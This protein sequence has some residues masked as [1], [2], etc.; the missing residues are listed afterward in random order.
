[1][2]FLT[3]LKRYIR[4]RLKARTAHGVHS[5]F[6][7]KLIHEIIE[8]ENTDYYIFKELRKTR[9]GLLGNKEKITITDLGAGSKVFKGNVRTVSQIASAGTSRPKFSRL[10]FRLINFCHAKQI[11]ELGTSIGLNT[12]YLAK[13]DSSAK[14]YSIE[15]CSGLHQFA[16]KLLQA[17]E[18]KN[19]TLLNGNFDKVFPELLEQLP[20]L[21][22]LFV[23]GN[24]RYEP[25]I[26]Y[27]TMALEKKTDSSV[28][29][30][31]DIHWSDGMEKA[32]EEIKAHPE[33]TLSLDLFY[34]GIIFFRKEQKEKEHFILKY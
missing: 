23:D 1:M 22:L 12:L 8:T 7:S 13:A 33:V 18:V 28:F 16:K 11:V 34:A 24:H 27:F 9:R 17:N 3:K 31:D 2:S 26:N 10:Y 30:F 4:Y 5:P 32:W 15:G 14:V 29:I 19:V 21:D 25:T 20:Q 6:V